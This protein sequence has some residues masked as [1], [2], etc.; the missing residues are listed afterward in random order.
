[1]TS[2]FAAAPILCIADPN[3]RDFV[4][5][6]FAYDHAVARA[7]AAAGFTPLVLGHRA[8]PADL[9][10]QAGAIPA[11]RDDIWARDPRFGP[12]GRWLDL[13]R[14]NRHFARDLLAALPP[15][16]LPPGSILL[17]HMLTER[18]MAGLAEVVEAQPR[19]VT[20]VALLRYQPEFYADAV[21]VAAFAR[22]RRAVAAG[23]SLRLASDSARLAR[24][25]S[26][27]A[28]LPVEVL[29]IPHTPACLPPPPPADGR[30]MHAVSLGNARDEKGFF[31]ILQAITLLRQSPQGLAGLR[32]TLQA[33]DAAADV[34][35]A[36]DA[37][38]ADLPPEVT[39]LPRALTPAEYD[40]VLASADLVLLPYWREIYE[41][42]TSGV[43]PEALGAGR[44]V[45]CTTGS[46]MADELALHGAGIEVADHD[47]AGL[48]QAI[49]L[50]QAQWPRLAQAARAGQ[51][52]CLARHGG[53]AFMTALLAPPVPVAPVAI[54][55][56]VQVF[57][58]WGDF[59]L[60]SAGASIRCNLMAEV[61]AGHVEEVRVAQS[62]GAAPL[63]Q[64][65][66]RI[67][68]QP[69]RRRI[70]AIRFLARNLFRLACWP[71]LGRARLG[72]A[73]FL[74][75]H[76]EAWADPI[77]RRRV[78]RLLA[79]ADAVLL[80]YGFWARIVRPECERLGI[81]CILTAHD[82]IE[83]AVT[84]SPLLRRWTAGLEEAARR[85]AGRLVTVSDSDA[86]RFAAQGL[87]PVI[88]PNPV[89]LAMLDRPLPAAPRAVLAGEGLAVPDQP[90]CLFVGSRFGPNIEAVAALRG[91]AAELAGQPGAPLIVVAGAA[92]EPGAGPGFLA[93]GRVSTPALAALYRAAAMAVIPLRSG[94]GA[95]LKT[96]EA[97]AAGLPVLGS[98]VAFRG[99]PVSHGQAVLVED[100]TA[101]WA[102]LITA[103]LADAAACARLGQ[104]A[105][106]VAEAY[107]HRRVMAAY[108]PL[109]GVPEA[110]RAPELPLLRA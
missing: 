43:L 51:A 45:I 78:R 58:P 90:F 62:G 75:Y 80:E 2:P 48:A 56:R 103:T 57:Y 88:I 38:A 87:S 99:L 55:A 26:R 20:I 13:R 70:W 64:G 69:E 22:L 23:A 74:W 12:P 19:H 44:P 32:F 42:R 28:G 98:A 46:W 72:E 59:H 21:C 47:P 66:I 110:M 50:A 63:R 79:G 52:A 30:P 86:R 24:R 39:L 95:S 15:Q 85:R 104:A 83:D 71:L 65:N 34:Q 6:H 96:L 76:L 84:A 1:M 60:R 5:H 11:F 29:P 91:I 14:R 41:A 68:A 35:A 17:P 92:A 105:R 97:M 109:L 37:F 10:A 16:G 7:G 54:P 81:P 53:Q 73:M 101:R 108:L 3:L 36:I 33:N 61:V 77:F 25:I 93:L 107:D 4:G 82:V 106:A 9:A 27:L 102:G 89:D 100:D 18:Q 8:L 49:R 31:E 67:E 40:E 94:T